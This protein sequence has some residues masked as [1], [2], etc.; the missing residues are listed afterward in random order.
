MAV[1]MVLILNG[2]SPG[3]TCLEMQL[4]HSHV[5]EEWKAGV[6]EVVQNI[7]LIKVEN[8]VLVKNSCGTS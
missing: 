2:I 4:T 6:I 1:S 7:I 5:Q 3:L 8:Q